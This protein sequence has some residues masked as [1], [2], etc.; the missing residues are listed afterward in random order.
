[1]AFAP[2]LAVSRG[3]GRV[4]VAG[5]VGVLFRPE[6]QSAGLE[7]DDELFWRVGLGYRLGS[8][9]R[10]VELDA[11]LSGGTAATDPFSA[12]NQSPVELLGW[13]SL[14]LNRE[15]VAFVGGGAGLAAGYG[16][17]DWRVLGGLRFH[18]DN[19][20]EDRDG[21]FRRA[22]RCPSEPEDR[23]DFEDL[24][25]CPD[26]DNDAD[27]VADAGDRCPAEKETANNFEDDDGCPD[28]AD[29]DKD[30]IA[31]NV[32]KCMLEP[33][34]VN[35]YQDTDGCP[36]DADADRDGVLAAQDKCLEVAEDADGFQDDDGCPDPDNDAD[37]VVDAEDRCPAEAGVVE[38]R[39]C[40]D[41]DRDADTVVDRVDN[42]PDEKGTP[43]NAGCPKKQLVVI[44][45]DKLE[46]LDS[47][48]FKTNKAVIEKKSYPLLDNV[49]AVLIA[50]P[51]IVKVRVEGHTD[52]QGPDEK[53]LV[54]SQK[55]AQAVV[56]YL[57]KKGVPAE[58]LEAVGFGETQPVGDNAFKEGRALNRRVVF[59][60]ISE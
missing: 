35:A 18:R 16:T 57:I 31:D 58:R 25:G 36:D 13:G 52:S 39:G 33:E 11:T 56:D 54:L 45:K 59:K 7:V 47:V 9:D 8:E 3:V 24:D 41:T 10:P 20:D 42:C 26:P 14:H 53:N 43:E 6:A 12:Q 60:I 34:T 21:I 49:A 5:N 27:G 15:V 17:P 1:V 19:D 32:D 46:I 28:V 40:P 23:D 29:G 22:D 30:G 37:G 4:R 48:Y 44:T 50:H 55:R 2:A 38:N 51:E